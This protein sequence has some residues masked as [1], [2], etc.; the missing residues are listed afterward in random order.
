VVNFLKCGKKFE[1]GSHYEPSREEKTLAGR[2][3]VLIEIKCKE[4]VYE[5]RIR[6]GCETKAK[7]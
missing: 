2:I 6:C 7:Y 3:E 5:L 4:A 1:P